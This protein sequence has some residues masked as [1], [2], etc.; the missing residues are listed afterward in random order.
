[1][2]KADKEALL[3]KRI[4]ERLRNSP[5]VRPFP[6]AVTQLMSACQ[7]DHSDSRKFEA[8]IECDPVL[9][10]TILR[11]ANSPLFCVSHSVTNIAH[12]VSILGLRKLKSVAMSVAGAAIFSEGNSAREERRQLWDHSIGCGVVAR[13]VARHMPSVDEDD[14]FLAGV[15]HDIGKLFFYDVIPDEYRHIDNSYTGRQLV[16]LETQLVGTTHESVGLMTTATWELPEEIRSAIGFHHRPEESKVHPEFAHVAHAADR[17]A[18]EWGIGSDA[19]PEADLD[20]IA[21]QLKLSQTQLEEIRADALPTFNDT[22]ATI[23]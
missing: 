18:R 19:R 10:A 17:L 4:N 23:G 2:H 20:G 11:M 12:A 14:A 1:M 22:L 6:A 7:D 5:E 15:F 9:S 16:E 13:C 8:I 21:T 3:A